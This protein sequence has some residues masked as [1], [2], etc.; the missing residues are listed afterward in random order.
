MKLAVRV[1]ERYGMAGRNRVSQ[2]VFFKMNTIGEETFLELCINS[3][4]RYISQ[5]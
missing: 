3:V 1:Y 2:A 5:H 4:E